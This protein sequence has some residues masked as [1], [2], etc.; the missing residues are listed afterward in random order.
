MVNRGFGFG[1]GGYSG[2]FLPYAIGPDNGYSPQP[3]VV[4]VQPPLAPQGNIQEPPREVHLIIHEYPQPGLTTAR[5]NGEPQTFGIVLKD[6]STRPATA[7]LV[8]DNMLK[9]VDPEGQ[10][11]Q[12][13]LDAV[14]RDATRKLNRQKNLNFWLP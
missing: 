2:D 3:N 5:A 14:D 7:V 13:S 11:L 8:N 6:G 4:V 9:Y 1:W 12:V 10:N